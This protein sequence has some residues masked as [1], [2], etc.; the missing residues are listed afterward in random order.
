MKIGFVS[1]GCSKNLVDSEKMMGML[2]S[3]NHELVNDASQAEAIVI[4]TCGFIN[5]AKEE[6]INTILEMAEYK[7]ENCKKLVVVGCLA[8]R[9]KAEL[10]AELPEIDR[11]I[12]IK[13]YDQMHE[14]LAEEFG[15]NLVTYRKSERMYSSKPWTAYLKIAEGC[16]NRCTYCAIPLIRGGNVSY[17]MEGLIEEAKAMAARGVKEL[18]L[19]AQDTTKYGLDLYGRYAL[20][21]LLEELNQIEGFVWIR[22]LYMYPDEINDELIA[23]MAKLDKVVPYFDIPMQHADDEMLVKMNR[24]GTMQDALTLI[25]KLRQTFV[26]PTLR[27]TYIVGFPGESEEAFANLASF[28]QKAQWDSLGAFTYS[29]EEDTAAYDMA[30]SLAEEVKE[31]RKSEIMKMQEA[32]SLKNNER[33]LGETIQVL[34]ESQEG[35]IGMYRGRGK[36]SAPDEVDGM[37]KFKAERA[38]PFGTFVNV[39]I[40]KALPYDLVGVEVE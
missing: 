26:R 40:T 6:G 3:G 22:I 31:Q 10:Q 39:K 11:I 24:R 33:F 29:P 14:I 16:S 30:D 13:E 27:S 18:V 38:I 25:E 35:L 4:N 23:T 1:L 37:V 21:A 5:S 15:E 28:T 20:G 9:Y 17:P 34:V 32:I 19:I 2:K 36:N 8:E 12:A 7:K